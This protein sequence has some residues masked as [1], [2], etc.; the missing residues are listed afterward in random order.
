MLLQNSFL[1]VVGLHA[2]LVCSD[3]FDSILIIFSQVFDLYKISRKTPAFVLKEE[4]KRRT[5]IDTGKKKLFFRL[6]FLSEQ[7]IFV[8]SNARS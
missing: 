2:K 4:H 6:F 5:K 3:L 8:N 1:C 7:N